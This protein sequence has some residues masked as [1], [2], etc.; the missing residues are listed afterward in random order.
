MKKK[1]KIDPKFWLGLS[2]DV[3][4]TEY[5]SGDSGSGMDITDGELTDDQFDALKKFA[6]ACESEFGFG[7]LFNDDG[8]RIDYIIN[9]AERTITVDVSE[10]H[11]EEVT[12]HE[13]TISAD[14]DLLPKE[15]ALAKTTMLVASPD[16]SK[17]R[18]I[19]KGQPVPED[20]EKTWEIQ[21]ADSDS[22]TYAIAFGSPYRFLRHKF[23]LVACSLDFEGAK[24]FAENHRLKGEDYLLFPAEFR[25]PSGAPI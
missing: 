2:A 16:F 20:D 7:Y 9:S 21:G 17:F 12:A 18:V 6:D 4:V 5:G 23:R 1:L 10:N 13:Y 8:G 15:K 14:G 25:L 11:V 19:Q 3:T 22:I 24:A